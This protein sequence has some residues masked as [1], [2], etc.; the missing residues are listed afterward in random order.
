[1]QRPLPTPPT[2]TTTECD[3][4]GRLFNSNRTLKIHRSHMHKPQSSTDTSNKPGFWPC[5]RDPR[6]ACCKCCGVFKETITSTTT[7]KTI[8]LKQ[9]TNC[10]TANVIYLLTCAKCKQQYV[11]RQQMQCSSEPT[12]IALILQW[13]QSSC[14]QWDTSEIAVASSWC[15]PQLRE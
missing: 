15:W 10:N 1:M 12:N 2:S 3:I 8:T 7:N 11:G 4:C 6:C 5:K 13:E 9:H 14:Q